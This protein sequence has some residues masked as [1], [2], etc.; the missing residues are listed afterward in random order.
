M[1]AE[2]AHQPLGEQSWPAWYEPAGVAALVAA[3]HRPWLEAASLLRHPV[4]RGRNVPDGGGQP[5]LLI[6]GF[7][8]GDTSLTMLRRWLRENGYWTCTSQIRFNVD[9][10]RLAVDRLERR[11]VEFT[12]RQGRP[13]VIIGQSRG[14]TLA[15]LVARRRPDRVV[16]IVTLG[17]PNVDPMAINPIVARQVR[18][19]AALGT[20]GV[21][22]LFSDDCLDGDCASEVREWMTLPFPAEV[23][24]VSVYSRSDGVVDWRACLDPAAEWVEVNSSHVGMSFHPGVYE[25]LAER[26]GQFAE[27]SRTEQAAQAG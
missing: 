16:G 6:P 13:T 25:V 2:G 10:T 19:V 22:G 15:K 1:P 18:L 21:R 7:L 12:D 8:A 5:V 4:W 27:R 24:Y 23:P 11:L 20:A 17:S 26:L 14:G 3:T 9:C